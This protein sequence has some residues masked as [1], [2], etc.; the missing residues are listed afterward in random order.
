MEQYASKEEYYRELQKRSR[1]PSGFSAGSVRL[2]FSPAERPS[3]QPYAMDLS[4]VRIDPPGGLA[5]GVFTR[6]SFPGAPVRIAKERLS[7]PP[8][9]GVLINNR[10]ANVC[11]PGGVED[12]EEVLLRLEGLLPGGRFLPASTGI[13]G[14]RLP[15]AEM[16]SALPGL[17][18][19]LSGDTVLPAAE[20]MMTTDSFPKVRSADVGEGRIVGIAKGA[21]MIEPNMATMLVFL[22][23][24]ISMPAADLDSC[25]ADIAN[26]TFNTITIDSDQSTSDMMLLFSSGRKDPVPYDDFSAALFEVCRGLAEDI[27]RNGEGTG[28]VIRVTVHGAPDVETAAGTAK[29]V[30]NS[31]LVKTAIYGND[32]NVGRIIMAVGKYTGNRGLS[33]DTGGVTVSLGGTRVF[34]GGSFHL[35][36][37]AEE[38]LSAYLRSAALP[39]VCPGYPVH[40]RLVEININLGAGRARAEVLGSDLSHQYITEN[41]DY[42][43]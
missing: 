28:H 14:W 21:G 17:T 32:P 3:P 29:S 42:R 2:S 6:N 1:L 19:C 13:I 15:K 18:G 11:A 8:V 26:R 22:F 5:A 25:C 7:Q 20:G 37:A 24:D 31:P 33:L 34:G 9:G 38:R 43:T 10:I 41:A 23:T 27:V 35:D 30:A 36:G 4:L 39:E 16:I 40:H 12:A